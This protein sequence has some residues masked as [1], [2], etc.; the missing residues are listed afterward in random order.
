MEFFIKVKIFSSFS[1]SCPWIQ[2]RNPDPDQD[3]PLNPDPIRI[4]N[5]EKMQRCRYGS[6]FGPWPLWEVDFGILICYIKILTAKKI[7]RSN[8]NNN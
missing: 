3:T 1:F 5:P 2:I 8:Y 4:H 6:G 7:L